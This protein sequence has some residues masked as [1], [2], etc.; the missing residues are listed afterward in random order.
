M[1]TKPPIARPVNAPAP[2]PP[3]PTNACVDFA[4]A[5]GFWIV[6]GLIT[7]SALAE[8]ANYAA[9]T[10][11]VNKSTNFFISQFSI[12]FMNSDYSISYS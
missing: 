1:I 2:S 10:P 6:R 11:A 5:T 12:I 4:A 9:K 8:V 3:N 7:S